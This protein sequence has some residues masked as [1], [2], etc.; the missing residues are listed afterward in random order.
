MSDKHPTLLHSPNHYTSG[1]HAGCAGSAA[2]RRRTSRETIDYD[3]PRELPDAWQG[4][5]YAA[6]SL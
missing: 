5:S 3:L 1:A 4:V 2:R 6:L